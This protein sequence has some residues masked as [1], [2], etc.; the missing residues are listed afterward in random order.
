MTSRILTDRIAVL[1]EELAVAQAQYE[2]VERE[3]KALRDAG[4]EQGVEIERMTAVIAAQ[5]VVIA[6]HQK[7]EILLENEVVSLLS[8]DAGAVFVPFR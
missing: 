3:T 6:A 4:K 8:M 7:K 5:Q 1:E 2:E